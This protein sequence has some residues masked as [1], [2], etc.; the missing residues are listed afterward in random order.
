MGLILLLMSF[1]L[2][3]AND[4]LQ[5]MDYGL[6]VNLVSIFLNSGQFCQG[7]EHSL[8]FSLWDS[9]HIPIITVS[10]SARR[11]IVYAS[12]SGKRVRH[13]GT[14]NTGIRGMPVQVRVE[15]WLYRVWVSFRCIL[16]VL[17]L[18]L[19]SYIKIFFPG[20]TISIIH[21]SASPSFK[22]GNVFLSSSIKVAIIQIGEHPDTFF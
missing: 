15:C 1:V 20:G 5:P 2:V 14:G 7:S 16:L 21:A 3:A 6:D 12:F 4:D 9:E 22:W 13:C 8:I 19:M 11:G 10:L 18:C 17:S